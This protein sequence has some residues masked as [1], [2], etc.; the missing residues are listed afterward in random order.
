MLWMY[1]N[2]TLCSQ[3]TFHK[4]L[5]LLDVNELLFYVSSPGINVS[6]RYTD[7]QHVWRRTVRILK[8]FV[9]VLECLE[10]LA[11]VTCLLSGEWSFS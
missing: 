6:I 11:N 3:S 7:K 2:F 9:A 5:L 8:T 1:V 4:A 10:V